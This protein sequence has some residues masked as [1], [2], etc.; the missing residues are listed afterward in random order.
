MHKYVIVSMSAQL[1]AA[2]K[3][4]SKR[5]NSQSSAS[6]DIWNSLPGYPVYPPGYC[7]NPMGFPHQGY[8]PVPQSQPPS[9]RWSPAPGYYVA[10]SGYYATPM[11][12]P[13]CYWGQP[14]P[15]PHLEADP[16]ALA[17]Q[18]HTNLAIWCY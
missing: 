4:L 3:E 16:L 14:F 5:N 15:Q 11:G 1:C 2:E 6:P 9:M 12:P 7:P 8:S 13:Q 18:V 10:P 17:H